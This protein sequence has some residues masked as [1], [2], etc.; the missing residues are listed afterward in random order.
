MKAGVTE[1][2]LFSFPFSLAQTNH[3]A[4]WALLRVR[5]SERFE[6]AM[7]P[8]RL[9]IRHLPSSFENVRYWHLADML[10]GSLNVRFQE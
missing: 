8:S 3:R 1:A 4:R 9:R 5:T 10:S 2:M 7:I 6:R